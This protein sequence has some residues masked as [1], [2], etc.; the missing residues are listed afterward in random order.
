MKVSPA[1][2]IKLSHFDVLANRI[3]ALERVAERMRKR[4]DLFLI[5]IVHNNKY[6]D[7]PKNESWKDRDQF[8]L[9]LLEARDR[10]ATD[11]GN[12]AIVGTCNPDDETTLGLFTL[13]IDVDSRG[14]YKSPDA[15]VE[16]LIQTMNTLTIRTRS[17]GYHLLFAAPASFAKELLENYGTV[18][19]HPRFAGE[20]FGEL[21]TFNQYVVGA[22]SYVP[23]L[24][25]DTR[26]FRPEATGYY[27]IYHDSSIR[28]INLQT[29]PTWV[30]FQSGGTK[31]GGNF[32]YESVQFD[33]AKID[34]Y[35]NTLWKNHDPSVIISTNGIPLDTVLK[36]DPTL[37]FLL[38]GPDA[39]AQKPDGTFQTRSDAD[40]SVVRQIHKYNFTPEQAWAILRVYRTYEKTLRPD[41][42]ERTISKIYG[43]TTD[44][45][46]D[47]LDT[48]DATHTQLLE[49]FTAS[50]DTEEIELTEFP[51]TLPDKKGIHLQG[52]PR[53]GKSYNANRWLGQFQN[54]I[55]VTPTHEI[56]IQ[57]HKTFVKLYPEKTSVR[58]IGKESTCNHINSE[59]Q[60]FDCN[61]CPYK[62]RHTTKPPIENVEEES[63]DEEVQITHWQMETVARELVAKYNHITPEV[64][65]D[66]YCHYYTLHYCQH[67]VDYVYTVP[68]YTIATNDS[69][70][71]LEHRE[72][73]I[74][75]E[76]T[77]FKYYYPADLLM[78]EYGHFGHG[79][80]LIN[81][82][83][84]SAIPALEYIEEMI[85]TT[86]KKDAEGKTIRVPKQRLQ[87]WDRA[88][89]GIIDS[90]REIHAAIEIFR[91]N[92]NAEIYDQTIDTITNIVIRSR[93]GTDTTPVCDLNNILKQRILLELTKFERDIHI[94]G[95]NGLVAFFEPF[96]YPYKDKPFVEIG[97][98]P[99]NLYLVGDKQTMIRKPE[100]ADRFVMIGFTEAH[101]FTKQIVE[102]PK[103]R[104]RLKITSFPYGKNFN[105]ITV[106]KV[107]DESKQ[108]RQKTI[109]SII[110][111]FIDEN[112]KNT[113]K[114]P[115]MIL[116]ASQQDQ[117]SVWSTN[118]SSE[119]YMTRKDNIDKLK[120]EW[121]NGR[122]L[123]FYQNSTISRGID[124]PWNDVIIVKNCSYA[125]PYLIAVMEYHNDQVE[126]LLE[127]IRV[128]REDMKSA[129][130]ANS[131]KDEEACMMMIHDLD[132]KIQSHQA[133]RIR[134]ENIRHSVY[135]D[136]TTNSCLR[137]TPVNGQREEQCKFI[138]VT[139]DDYGYLN[140]D[141]RRDMNK[142]DIVSKSEIREIVTIVRNCVSQVNP[143]L[144]TDREFYLSGSH[145]TDITDENVDLIETNASAIQWGKSYT[146]SNAYIET[147]FAETS[148]ALI[149]DDILN[150]DSV[151]EIARHMIRKPNFIT[152][153][154]DDAN[155]SKTIYSNSLI[156][157][158]QGRLKRK[159]FAPKDYRYAIQYLIKKKWVSVIGTR[160]LRKYNFQKQ[161]E[162]EISSANY[163]DA[164]TVYSFV[165][166]DYNRNQIYK[167]T[168]GEITL[169]ML[170]LS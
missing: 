105:L 170:K 114:M 87:K 138:I 94:S 88:I 44:G 70:T 41:Y 60:R 86:T 142:I 122:G 31:P 3:A 2:D 106:R 72:I 153:S 84:A 110:R 63:D 81:D 161:D 162:E 130:E 159:P 96:L 6:P 156:K 109:Q 45:P 73:M 29:F 52:L 59:G 98:N 97:R 61:N 56:L 107:G 80:T 76:D 131:R 127:Q 157:W 47:T 35:I 11:G 65:P 39:V 118:Q 17:G 54:G 19:P 24:E 75:D 143:K 140:P 120:R 103:D 149:D 36:N 25:D 42:M 18:N 30:S 28:V 68:Y 21:R 66:Y 43:Q 55:F 101:L 23:R 38:E 1:S 5:P 139:E 77:A 112:T 102:N 48:L 69:I 169:T 27:E 40:F 164:H 160:S 57:Q 167:D 15:K 50:D 166:Y 95:D 123:A 92:G 79:T 141:A 90:I 128:I 74:I 108:K 126:A 165:T 132:V 148:V 137:P 154:S 33:N 91:N 16:E 152:P 12:F 8:G 64:I 53:T 117:E 34:E 51:D 83:L 10:L 133:E 93:G 150:S 99:K 49:Q 9:T 26:Q 151:Q 145:V 144:M 89:L 85:T 32:E 113:W 135:M 78:L 125:Q 71:Q 147:Y 22:G 4:L 134:T 111:A 82:K 46:L 104:L 62:P 115:F 100:C 155:M 136:E 119:V 158:A 116:T 20:E 121:L 124:V 67:E 37:S 163:D 14:E 58:L 168:D 13:D 146:E 129:I 7:V